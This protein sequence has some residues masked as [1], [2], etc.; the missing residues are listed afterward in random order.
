MT[1]FDRMFSL[2]LVMAV[3]PFTNKLKELVLTKT[4]GFNYE[5]RKMEI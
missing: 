5:T 3:N 2:R 4:Q 1:V